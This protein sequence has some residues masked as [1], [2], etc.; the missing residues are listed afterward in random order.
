MKIRALTGVRELRVRDHGNLARIEVGKTERQLFFDEH[1][2]DEIA[3]SL[4][5]FGYSY[6]ALD[7]S[8]YKSGSMLGSSAVGDGKKR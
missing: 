1:V 7:L 4:K 2:L 8:G 6:V 5:E 3:K